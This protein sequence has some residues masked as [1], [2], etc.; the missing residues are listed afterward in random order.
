MSMPKFP[1]SCEIL[2]REDAANAILSS[3]AMEEA[4]LSH[5]LNAE[6]EKIQ[7]V[8]EKDSTDTDSQLILDVNKSVAHLIEVINDAQIILKNKMRLAISILPDCNCQQK[9]PCPDS[10]PLKPQCPKPPPS[11][12]SCPSPQEPPCSK[13]PSP[14]VCKPCI[15][16][17][18]VSDNFVWPG[19]SALMLEEYNSC[20]KYKHGHDCIRV[21]RLRGDT[22]VL[23][24]ANSAY[25]VE[26]DLRL[27]TSS[28][29]LI[30]ATAVQDD[31]IIFEKE[32]SHKPEKHIIH[33]MDAIEIP[34][35]HRAAKFSLRLLSQKN[36]RVEEGIVSVTHLDF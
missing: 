14:G 20:D 6:G 8:L 22:Y 30:A 12:P 24:P 32:Y 16:R 35:Q 19:S 36:I 5:I 29:V 26:F 17:F 18:L 25:R 3:I 33:I 13:P 28:P 34:K 27:K 4:A 23:L 21:C 9:P 2:T 1:Q 15:C 31:D 7:H 11:K 10:P